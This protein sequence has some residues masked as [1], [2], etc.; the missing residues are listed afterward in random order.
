MI[1]VDTSV[2]ID[3]LRREDSELAALLESEQVLIHDLVIEE[4]ACGS[5]KDRAGTLALLGRLPRAVVARHEEVLHYVDRHA[6]HGTGIGAIDAHLLASAALS[7]AGVLT[8]D[9][10]LRREAERLRLSPPVQ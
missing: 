7:G 4:L 6:L 2:W 8:R 3:H 5:L 9:R 1:L 10:T